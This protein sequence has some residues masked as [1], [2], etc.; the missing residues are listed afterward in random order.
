VG[1]HT[2]TFR[3]SDAG[4]SIGTASVTIVV[5]ADPVDPA[6]TVRIL[7]PTSGTVYTFEGSPVRVF[8]TW[9]A[10]DVPDG[11]IPFE[12]L[13]WTIQRNVGAGWTPE[14]TLTVQQQRICVRFDPFGGC[15]L[16]GTS[17]WVDL[18]PT[19]SATRTTYKIWLR[20]TDSGERTGQ[21]DTIIHIDQLI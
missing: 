2:L 7:T 18:A 20:A 10:S 17:Y 8:L 3:G 1:T 9:S 11:P 12:E 21:H 15:S 14:Q 5:E 6:P 16:Y 19:D 13:S 4:G